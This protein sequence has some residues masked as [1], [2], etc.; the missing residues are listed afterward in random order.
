[1]IDGEHATAKILP[2]Y[3][4]KAEA[5][6]GS[7]LTSAGATAVANAGVNAIVSLVFHRATVAVAVVEEG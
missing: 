7:G 5:W 4:D 1:M 3:R 6:W 2:G